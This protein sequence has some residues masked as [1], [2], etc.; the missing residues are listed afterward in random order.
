[1]ITTSAITESCSC[2]P[3]LI[4]LF[5]TQ[6]S[7]TDITLLTAVKST[8]LQVSFVRTTVPAVFNTPIEGMRYSPM[9]G[10][11]VQIVATLG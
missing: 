5:P 3:P 6:N 4:P 7:R 11:I 8:L 2:S 1:M 9:G 10:L